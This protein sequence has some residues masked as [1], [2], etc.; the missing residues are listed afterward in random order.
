MS[1]LLAAFSYSDTLVVILSD[2]CYTIMLGWERKSVWN[3]DG[4][5]PLDTWVVIHDRLSLSV[6]LSSEL[7]II[8]L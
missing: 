5:Y 1:C 7:I 8:D 3:V 2:C 4:Y 6:E